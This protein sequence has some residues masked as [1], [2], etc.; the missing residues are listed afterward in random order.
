[1]LHLTK[2][3]ILHELHALDRKVVAAAKRYEESPQEARG[4]GFIC[5]G[6]GRVSTCTNTAVYLAERLDGDVYGYYIEDNPTAKMGEA[7]GGHDFSIID[8]RWLLDFWAQDVYQLPWLY[9]LE[10]PKDAEA[11]KALY[12]FHESW[13]KMPPEDF[14]SQTQFIRESEEPY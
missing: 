1:M 3:Q 10:D 6:V 13:T 8:E 14:T 4:D 9:D 11:V 2:N 12:G 5:E 7:E